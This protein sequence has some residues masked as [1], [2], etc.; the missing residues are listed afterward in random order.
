VCRLWCRSSLPLLLVACYLLPPVCCLLQSCGSLRF[1]LAGGPKGPSSLFPVHVAPIPH[2]P[3]LLQS[4]SASVSALGHLFCFAFPV[5]SFLRAWRGRLCVFLSFLFRPRGVR[6]EE[7]RSVSVHTVHVR[8]LVY[9][10]DPV[11]TLGIGMY[12]GMC[13]E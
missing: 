4:A 5:C 12:W 10:R 1:R 3:T 7:S 11:G 9:S 13:A 2:G 6:R 8:H